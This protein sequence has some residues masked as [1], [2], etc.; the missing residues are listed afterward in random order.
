MLKLKNL[1]KEVYDNY[2]I[3]Q[4]EKP[5]FLQSHSYGEFAKV[6]KSLTP[7][8]LGL[9]NENN[10]IV[11]A[12]MVFQK[13]LPFNYSGLYIPAG[14]TI[15]Y[16]KKHLVKTLTRALTNFA[17][18]KKAIFIKIS[19]YI[20]EDISEDDLNEIKSN[21]K[22]AGFK[23]EDENKHLKIMLPLSS[24]V[25]DLDKDI[26]EIENNF[27]EST[28]DYLAKAIKLN[29][30]TVLGN[31]TNIKDLHQ[32][33][34][35]K[36]KETKYN[37]DYF[38]TLYEIFNGS[39]NTK[40]SIILGKV[41]LNKT[42]KTLERNLKKVNDQISILPIDS[43]TKSSKSKL[44]DLTKQKEEIIKEIEKF[45]GYKQKHGN[46]V[47]MSAHLIIQ[48]GPNAWITH[49]YDSNTIKDTYLKYNTY[50]KDIK[51]CKDE[52]ITSLEQTNSNILKDNYNA[53]E[54]KYLGQYNYI[55]NP[56]MYFI[57]T[58]IKKKTN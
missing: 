33:M 45:Q 21:L 36:E 40:A 27:K 54:V 52:N 4:K 49:A 18:T 56:I 12:T 28:K 1:D 9:V 37:E 30:E 53:K 15:D 3:S 34:K 32:L 55:T 19:P 57:I 39:K 6:K 38:E 8:Y 5:H 2:V 16:N 50:Y 11:A 46:E 42:I 7:Y 58:K 13:S 43:L 10:E 29:T 25:L 23:K 22:D 24:N 44:V 17:K 41:N 35:S 31:K 51:Y 48:Y 20:D 47:T 26:E 14:F